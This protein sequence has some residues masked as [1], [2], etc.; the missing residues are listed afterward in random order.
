MSP[1]DWII[2]R[3]RTQRPLPAEQPSNRPRTTCAVCG[4]DWLGRRKMCPA[5]HT[6]IEVRTDAA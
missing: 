3:P 5:C 6:R 2:T 1:Y 4:W